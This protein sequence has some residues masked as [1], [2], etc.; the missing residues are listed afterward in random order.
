MYADLRWE[1]PSVNKRKLNSRRRLDRTRAEQEKFISR[2]FKLFRHLMTTPAMIQRMTALIEVND[3]KGLIE[4]AD[5]QIKR[6][7]NAL[8]ISFINVATAEAQEQ[9]KQLKLNAAVEIQK[10]TPLFDFSIAFNPVDQRVIDLM[11]ENTLRFITD[12]T[13]AQREAIRQAL[14][15]GLSEGKGAGAIANMIRDTIGLTPYQREMVQNYQSALEQGTQD[16]LNRAL[17]DHRFDG[18]VQ[19]VIDGGDPLSASQIENMLGAYTDRLLDH[20][21]EMIARTEAGAIIEQ[22]RDEALHQVLEQA[23]IN[24]E[25]TAKEWLATDDGRTRP[26]HSAL[27]GQVK[28]LNEPFVSPVSGAELMYPHDTSAPPGE[29]INCRC[30]VLHHVFTTKEELDAFMSSR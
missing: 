1:L 10:A 29:H 24:E 7:G 16:A 9:V 5:E 8:T 25:F 30:A 11:L 4:I 19:A 18:T 12:V 22:A 28:L 27:N 23:G 3:K 21:A 13:N 26:S 14:A 6:L 20:R 15:Q 17:R 2:Q